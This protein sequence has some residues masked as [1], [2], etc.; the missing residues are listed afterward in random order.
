MMDASGHA[1]RQATERTDVA[2]SL[3]A[4][5][6]LEPGT[7]RVAARWEGDESY[8][9]FEV[10]QSLDLTRA[11]VQ[12][13]VEL[14]DA[15]RI[16][17]EQAQHEVDVRASSDEG[18]AGLWI[19]VRDEL[20]R[21]LCAGRT[22]DDGHVRLTL[23]RAD[24]GEPGYR[25][26]VVRTGGDE[27]RGPARTEVPL[28][29]FRRAAVELTA[30]DRRV[31]VGSEI[32]VSGRLHD[33]A[34]PLSRRAV[35]LFIDGA[36]AET[37]FTDD[38]G[39]FERP[40]ELGSEGVVAL[41]ARYES[42]A[43]W[44]TSASSEALLIMVERGGSPP[45]PWLLAPTMLCALFVGWVSRRSS[46]R[47]SPSEGAVL[48][49]ATVPGVELTRPVSA[50]ARRRDVAG[51]IL[52]VDEGG[53]I[54][55]AT[56]E[57]RTAFE[58]KEVRSGPNGRFSIADL[59][60]AIWHLEVRAEGYAPNEAVIQL[61]HRGQWSDVRIR[62]ASF[63]NIALA[64][65]RPVAEALAPPHARWALWTPRELVERAEGDT[66]AEVEALTAELERAAYGSAA[67][68]PSEVESIGKRA[69][70][71]ARALDES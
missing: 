9:Q 4:V 20:G 64:K 67:P 19:E 45:W 3:E 65:Y 1:L 5:F 18:G 55:N 48:P 39:R 14:G 54:E 70:R 37:V 51:T 23:E 10:G 38:E 13:V 29:R 17:L 24:L 57:L 25:P 43:P 41:V 68:S 26:M 58:R 2:G 46:G 52:D 27:L 32:L 62:L 53:P 36:H 21:E 61:P 28:V 22:D 49:P 6:P 59:E 35:G 50:E 47:T 71:I 60:G 44:W 69:A 12:L 7:Y 15:G 31:R 16:D 56:I 40:L 66:R 8:R 30:S 33:S 42:D 11:H 63:R 34:E